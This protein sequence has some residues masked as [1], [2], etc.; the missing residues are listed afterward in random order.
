MSVVGHS[1]SKFSLVFANDFLHIWLQPP[2]DNFLPA[3][4]GFTQYSDNFMIVT[5][6]SDYLFA[7]RAY[8]TLSPVLRLILSRLY[9]RHNSACEITEML[10]LRRSLFVLPLYEVYS[11][12]KLRLFYTLMLLYDVPTWCVKCFRTDFRKGCYGV[13]HFVKS[14]SVFFAFSVQ[15]LVTID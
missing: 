1:R 4:I 8:G 9:L 2:F 13:N 5:A 10:T 15:C 6:E 7:Y 3:F 12:E 11:Y 14:I